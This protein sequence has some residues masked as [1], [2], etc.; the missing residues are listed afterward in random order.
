MPRSSWSS[1]IIVRETRE[2]GLEMVCH[3]GRMTE[4]GYALSGGRGVFFW[5]MVGERWWGC[6]L[7]LG[8]FKS[9]PLMGVVENFQDA[10]YISWN[11]ETC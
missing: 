9:N 6:E 1:R 2:G 8:N 7:S 5:V 4:C 3:A 10:L 11:A